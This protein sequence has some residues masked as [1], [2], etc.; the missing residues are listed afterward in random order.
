MNLRLGK[1]SNIPITIASDWFIFVAVYLLM[2]LFS[3]SLMSF[4]NTGLAILAITSIILLHELGH[5]FAARYFGARTNAITLH[6]YGGL[7]EVN[8]ND[9]PQLLAKPYKSL[10]V[11][12][13]GPM[14]NV[15]LFILFS[16]IAKSLAS[17]PTALF[18]VKYLQIVNLGL[19][20]FNLLPVFPLDGG[21]IFY[22][23]LRMVFSKKVSI[24]TT[25][26]VGVIGSIGFVFLA[27][28]FHALMLGFIGLMTLL[29]SLKAPKHPLFQ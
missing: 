19:A 14:V 15:L 3:S 17:Y 5:S 20:V 22:S 7:A 23:L 11:W 2:T 12:L 10:L 18:Y 25:S 6:C 28:K 26:V 8:Q 24:Y 13:A 9:W 1:I 21:G 29:S 16:S 27:F 4:F